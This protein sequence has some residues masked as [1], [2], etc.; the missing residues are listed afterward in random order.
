VY[1]G[2]PIEVNGEVLGTICALHNEPYD[3]D[4]GSPSLRSRL[5]ELRAAIEQDLA[6][7]A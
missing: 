1:L 2:Y 6:S 4:A 5:E 3:F 7:A